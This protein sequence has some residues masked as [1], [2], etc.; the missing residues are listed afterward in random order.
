VFFLET[1]RTNIFVSRIPFVPSRL[2]HL[3]WRHSSVSNF[4]SAD[5]N[6][7]RY[8]RNIKIDITDERYP[9]FWFSNSMRSLSYCFCIYAATGRSLFHIENQER[10]LMSFK[11][12]VS[13]LCSKG[14]IL[15]F[16][17]LFDDR[18]SKERQLGKFANDNRNITIRIDKKEMIIIFHIAEWTIRWWRRLNQGQEH[19]WYQI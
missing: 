14:S 10:Q 13:F 7:I 18:R 16:P 1:C 4:L 9:L 5:E 6:W 19:K 2:Q 3:Q 11:M 17:V 15:E 12:I 8:S